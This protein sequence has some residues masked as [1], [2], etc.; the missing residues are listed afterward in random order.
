M[1][2]ATYATQRGNELIAPAAALVLL[3]TVLGWD[4]LRI[5]RSSHRSAMLGA[6]RTLHSATLVDLR[7][8]AWRAAVLAE[9]LLLW[10]VEAA[11]GAAGVAGADCADGVGPALRHF[12][13]LVCAVAN[14]GLQ[15]AENMARGA[16]GVQ[17]ALAVCSLPAHPPFQA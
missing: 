13:A 6:M 17:A 8:G 15:P 11:R 3:A 12:I 9:P 10:C 2:D 5:K 4:F 14:V 1:G 7:D 16:F